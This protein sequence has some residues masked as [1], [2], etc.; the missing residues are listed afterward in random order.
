MIGVPIQG[1]IDRAGESLAAFQKSYE[2]LFQEE[3]N[4]R[5]L[6]EDRARSYAQLLAELGRLLDAQE[7]DRRRRADPLFPNSLD[8]SQWRDFLREIVGRR[9]T[10]QASAGWADNAG[11]LPATVQAGAGERESE[12]ERLRTQVYQLTEALH[13]AQT[14]P[15]RSGQGNGATQGNRGPVAA[16]GFQRSAGS[17]QPVGENSE[18]V[19]VGGAEGTR[20]KAA[21]PSPL[22]DVPALPLKAPGRYADLFRRPEDWQKKALA[23]AILGITGWSLRLAIADAIAAQ[24][25]A[26]SAMSSSW[27][28]VYS[29]LESAGLWAQR[30]VEPAN[31]LTAH[32]QVVTLTDLGRKVLRTVGLQP[33]P[34][35]WDRLMGERGGDAQGKHAGLVSAFT[36]HA[37]LRGFATEVCPQVAPPSEPD[38]LLTQGDERVYVEVEADSGEAERL[39]QKWRNQAGLQGCVAFCATAAETRKALAEDARHAVSKGMATDLATLIGWVNAEDYS[40]LWAERWP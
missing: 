24:G 23:L 9:A 29:E 35:E 33:V 37:R 39:K 30:T 2:S 40:S 5:A 14:A 25:A 32:I 11:A 28:T 13:V 34:S 19:T 17:P 21:R 4:L 7:M 18:S 3:R 15:T 16:G 22:V 6:A 10:P 27:K 20:A 31:G 38:V 8:P 36:Y 12:L 1:A 26:A